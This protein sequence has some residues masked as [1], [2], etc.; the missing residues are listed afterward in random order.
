MKIYKNTL[1]SI[2][3]GLL[4]TFLLVAA[5]HAQEKLTSRV[6]LIPLDDRPPCL[7]KPVELG[8][9]AD[10]EIVTP[11]RE[12]LGKFTRFGESDK[13]IEW[14]KK[15]DLRKFDAAIVSLDMLAYGGLVA[16]REYE[17]TRITAQ[18]R[19]DFVR[20][21]KRKNPKLPIYG[22][23]V[24]MRLAP[25]GNVTNEAYRVKLSRWAEISSEKENAK[26]QEEARKL[27]KEIPAEALMNYKKARE[28]DL[29]GNLQ[30]IDLAKQ[31]VFDYLIVSQDDAHP[32]GVHIAERESLIRKVKELKIEG[33]VPVQPGAD[34]VSMLLMARFFG[35]DRKYSPRIFPIY[36]SEESRTKVMPFEDRKLHETI[37]FHIKSVGA[38]EVSSAA[39]A[40][41]L[42]YAF[43]SRFE[44]GRAKTFVDKIERSV[45]AGKK[46]M[47]I[48]V[49]PSAKTEGGDPDFS[50]DLKNR[51]VFRQL[52]AYAAWNTAGNMIGTAL[53]QALIYN[54]SRNVFPIIGEPTNY[55][56]DRP[57]MKK[58]IVAFSR[59]T[60]AQDWFLFHRWMDDYVYNT[61]IRAEVRKYA[62]EKGWQQLRFDEKQSRE[63]EAVVY[64]KIQERYEQDKKALFGGKNALNADCNFS[65]KVKFYLPWNRA[66]EAEIDFDLNCG[67]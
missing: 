55:E 48:D 42:F 17:T 47:V 25:T 65:D 8:A 15:Q 9:I 4:F 6:L 27:E 11:P 33:K 61:L 38:T 37:T 53:P 51:S 56:R 67:K 22:S 40:E 63:V 16:M 41:I 26:L 57:R 49:D 50:E 34:E 36:S 64:P 28:R 23:S 35:V 1:S 3:K 43:G 30:A 2:F 12:L 45:K 13:I 21:M 66:F 5:T 7:Q 62:R 52:H 46:V 20:E 59:V 44:P 39:D 32:T 54:S 10:A 18:K 60:E 14:L 19:I 58:N 24:I 31:G 29:A